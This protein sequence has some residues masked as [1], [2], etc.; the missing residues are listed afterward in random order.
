MGVGG[1]EVGK[2]GEGD[3]AD[4]GKG[5]ED[6]GK[7][8]GGVEKGAVL[9]EDKG[10]AADG[11]HVGGVGLD[12]E[13][14]ERDGGGQAGEGLSRGR[15]K[16]A[17]NAEPDI[18]TAHDGMAEEIGGEGDAVEENGGQFVGPGLQNAEEGTPGSGA[19][20]DN[21]ATEAYGKGKLDLEGIALGGT[22]IEG[23]ANAIEAN[24]TNEGAGVGTEGTFKEV[25][26]V[27]AGGGNA[28]RVES[29]GGR[30]VEGATNFS[31]PI[32]GTDGTVDA[33]GNAEV[34]GLFDEACVIRDDARVAKVEMGVE[35]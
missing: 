18:R 7:I 28:P 34:D 9:A 5:A 19:M 26:P 27:W 16:G 2:F 25:G 10:L 31:V 6:K 14:V 32:L 21:G 8:G 23:L 33:T 29:E 22:A 35:H 4:S 30:D 15:E 3:A 13:A 20:K 1:G 11:K 12:K 24:F 17:A